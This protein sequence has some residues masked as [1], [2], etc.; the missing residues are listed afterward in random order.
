M[1]PGDSFTQNLDRHYRILGVCWV[2]YGI[3]RLAMAVWLALFSNTATV[4]FGALLNR[5]PSPFAM[6]SA[7]HFFYGVLVAL[8]AV[9]GILGILA[10]AAL[11]AGNPLGR[12]LAI[13]AG[14]LFALKHT[15]RNYA[16]NLQPHCAADVESQTNFRSR[17]WRS[18]APL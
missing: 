11:L 5:V 4:M 13:I 6:M 7:F 3:V 9:C 10:G 14:F 2:L 16:R 8:S 18:C 1:V 12:T 17:V 15:A